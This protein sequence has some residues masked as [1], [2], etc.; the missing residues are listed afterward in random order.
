MR[1]TALAMLAGA[2]L[3]GMTGPAQAAWKTYVSHK[4]GFAIDMPGKVTPGTGIFGGRTS[5]PQESIVFRSEENNIKYE[6]TVFNYVQAKAT[7]ASLIGEVEFQFQDKAKLL[8]DTFSRIKSGKNWVYGRKIV[9][10]LPKNGGRAKTAF[11][12]SKGY[13][14]WLQAT[15]LPA[16]GKYDSP[17]AAR[18]LDSIRLDLA[19]A[20]KD[21]TELPMPALE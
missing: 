7:S 19:S 10:D 1:L 2:M 6:V 4:I 5:G 17:D 21:A 16:N 13:I 15:V 14:L 3:A 8:S 11:Y 9:V 12:F 20:P 18:F